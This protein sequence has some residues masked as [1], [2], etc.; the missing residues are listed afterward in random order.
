MI[1]YNSDDFIINEPTAVTLGNFDGIH[2]GHQELIGTVLDYS[3][4]LGLKSVI[5]SFEPHPVQFFNKDESFRTMF[6]THE[7]AYVAERMGIDVL[8][9]YPFTLEFAHTTPEKFVDL[10]VKRT[11]CKVLVVGENYCFGSDR[12][13]NLGTLRVLGEARGIKVI[14]IPSVKMNDV[15]VSSTRI[16]GLINYGDMEQVAALL[17]KPYF[18]M[19]RIIHGDMRG[20]TMNYPTL[21]MIPEDR[22][23]LPPNG[24]YFSAVVL[25]GKKYFSMSNIGTNPTFDG[26]VKHMETHVIDVDLGDVYDKEAVVYIYKRIRGERK[27]KDMQELMAQLDDDKK[28]CIKWSSE[29]E[30]LK[31]SV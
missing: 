10:L 1:I 3:K 20:R 16:R 4:R 31:Y 13:G 22:K 28:V 5:F 27:F 8:V 9:Q 15:R 26:K 7:K 17:N 12:C 18:V 24:V 30:V 23:L 29:L 25:D 19:S 21:N 2:L 6:D 11:N 14:G